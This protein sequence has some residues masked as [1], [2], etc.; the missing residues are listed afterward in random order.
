MSEEISMT[1]AFYWLLLSHDSWPLA[2]MTL[3]IV[4][5]VNYPDLDTD[6]KFEDIPKY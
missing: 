3:A 4:C 5:S 2:L 1:S 6:K